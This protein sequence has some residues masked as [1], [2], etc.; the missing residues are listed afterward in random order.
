EEGRYEI[1]ELVEKL[2]GAQPFGMQKSLAPVIDILNGDDATLILDVKVRVGTDFSKL[3][4]ELQAQIF[5]SVEADGIRKDNVIILSY[6]RGDLYIDMSRLNASLGKIHVSN[7]MGKLSAFTSTPSAAAKAGV[8]EEM[9]NAI[10]GYMDVL[11]NNAAT[12]VVSQEDILNAIINLRLDAAKGIALEIFYGSVY[13]AIKYFVSE[14]LADTME[15]IAT[16]SNPSLELGV[17]YSVDLSVKLS[18]PTTIYNDEEYRQLAGWATAAQNYFGY[19]G[20]KTMLYELYD[21][22]SSVATEKLLYGAEYATYPK[23]TNV[24][25]YSTLVIRDSLFIDYFD[26]IISALIDRYGSYAVDVQELKAILDQYESDIADELK[27]ALT[28]VYDAIKGNGVSFVTLAEVVAALGREEIPSAY[29]ELVR[30]AKDYSGYLSRGERKAVAFAVQATFGGEYGRLS[31]TVVT[32]AKNAYTMLENLLLK[33]VIPE[34]TSTYYEGFVSELL[35]TRGLPV[36]ITIHDAVESMIKTTG[37]YYV[38]ENTPAAEKIATVNEL[39]TETSFTINGNTVYGWYN[40][41]VS[42][43]DYFDNNACKEMLFDYVLTEIYANK[44]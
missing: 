23:E 9:Y 26:V 16:F 38:I 31:D 4:D 6:I 29:K 11:P 14:E 28:V 13:T 27:D 19:T 22:A 18:V 12:Q 37:L 15:M 30:F 8:T 5:V 21:N 24:Y 39:I 44:T 33:K 35:R 42:R 2:I 41:F 3:M 17:D 34:S 43:Y 10:K 20:Q 36:T 32:D 7:L 25:G 1:K 40:S